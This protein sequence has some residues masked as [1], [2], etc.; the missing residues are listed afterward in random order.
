MAV[1]VTNQLSFQSEQS[2]AIFTLLKTAPAQVTEQRCSPAPRAAPP[3]NPAP[4]AA[5]PRTPAPRAPLR[6]GQPLRA[7]PRPVAG[8][9]GWCGAAWHRGPCASCTPSYSPCTHRKSLQWHWI[10]GRGHSPLSGGPMRSHVVH[11]RKDNRSGVTG[12]G[13]E[14]AS[15]PQPKI[16]PT[17]AT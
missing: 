15:P 16:A 10:R 3:R 1:R 4:R 13:R 11:E 2:V 8:T 9:H 7:P 12:L 14:I 17:R 5:P 6:P